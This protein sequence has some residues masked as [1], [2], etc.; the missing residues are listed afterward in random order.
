MLRGCAPRILLSVICLTFVGCVRDLDRQWGSEAGQDAGPDG[1]LDASPEAGRD[2]VPDDDLDVSTDA[3]VERPSDTGRDAVVDANAADATPCEPVLDVD[4]NG[5]A[6]GATDGGLITRYLFGFRGDSLVD[7]DEAVA[8]DCTRCVAADI[9]PFLEANLAHLDV[10]RNATAEALA[11]GLLI[12][13]YLDG[14]RGP[15]LISGATAADCERLH[16][17]RDRCL[18]R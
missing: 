5:S 10:D 17:G 2:A 7:S 1:D 8:T 11:D 6:V 18:S 12:R 13:R 15:D 3:K 14:Q 16:S 9:E 4:G